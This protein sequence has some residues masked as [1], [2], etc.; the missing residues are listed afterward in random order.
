MPIADSARRVRM[1]IGWPSMTNVP[2]VVTRAPGTTWAAMAPAITDRAALPVHRKRRWGFAMTLAAGDYCPPPMALTP[3]AALDLLRSPFALEDL[4]GSE[5]FVVDAS[6]G[7]VELGAAAA[8]LRA[9][10]CVTVAVADTSPNAPRR[11]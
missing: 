1:L 6:G 7:P 11:G 9:L 5:A 3:D 2:A 8:T 4:G 10:P